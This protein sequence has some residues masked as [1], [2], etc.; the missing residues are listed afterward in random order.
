M[1][2][3]SRGSARAEP[4]LPFQVY[5][6]SPPGQERRHAVRYFCNLAAHCWLLGDATGFCRSATVLNISGGGVGFVS[7]QRFEPGKVL[8]IEMSNAPGTLAR[9]IL[10]QVIH[11]QPGQ[12]GNGW[13]HGCAFCDPLS[14]DALKNLLG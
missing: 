9:T 2:A 8:V 1:L 7:G 12:G 13:S 6:A 11:V 10:A 4:V 5:Q 14:E 3:G